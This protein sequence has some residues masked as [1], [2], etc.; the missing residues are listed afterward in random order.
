MDHTHEVADWCSC[1]DTSGPT[2]EQ[3]QA[4][5]AQRRIEGLDTDPSAFALSILGTN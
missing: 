4:Y 5:F 1:W 3:F 2:T